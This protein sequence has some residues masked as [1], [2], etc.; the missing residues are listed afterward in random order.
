[1]KNTQST[2]ISVGDTRTKLKWLLLACLVLYCAEAHAHGGV[3]LEDDLC[4]IQIGFYKA[5]F[6]IY[7][8]QTSRHEEFCED[9]PHADESVFVMEYLHDS[10]R[11]SPIEFRIIR[12][13]HNRGRFAKRKDIDKIDDLDQHTVFYQPPSVQPYGVFLALHQFREEGNYIGIVTTEN[14][15]NDSVYTAVFPFRVGGRD[16][17][18][19]PL[20]IALAILL[21]LNYWLINGGY[22]R[23]H[24][25]LK[26]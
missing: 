10:L 15:G 6:T 11:E 26:S 17:G 23:I 8:P 19:I 24:K 14:P 9:I 5:H 13:V 21:Q 3:F 4:V 16:W 1:M 20:L 12:D 18:Y 22:A 2:G 7:Q 25:K